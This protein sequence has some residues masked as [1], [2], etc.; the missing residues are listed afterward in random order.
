MVFLFLLLLVLLS[1]L[2]NSLYSLQPKNGIRYFEYIL[3]LL[4]RPD[5]IYRIF[6]VSIETDC[7]KCTLHRDYSRLSLSI[8]MALRIVLDEFL[9]AH[10]ATTMTKNNLSLLGVAKSNIFPNTTI[11]RVIY[12]QFE[13]VEV[14]SHFSFSGA[15]QGLLKANKSNE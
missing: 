11:S 2:P 3:R 12:V 5:F 1:S 13:S 14:W 9:P 6:I 10:K 7:I 8:R 15:F 4:C